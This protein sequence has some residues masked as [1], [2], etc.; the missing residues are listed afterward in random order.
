M[1]KCI[2]QFARVV[3]SLFVVDLTSYNEGL[4]EESSHNGVNESLGLFDFVSNISYF[5]ETTII[6]LFSKVDAFLAKLNSRPLQHPSY[7]PADGDDL[8]QAIDHLR[9]Q[10]A[11]RGRSSDLLRSHIIGG[12]SGS[13]ILGTYRFIPDRVRDVVLERQ[14]TNVLRMAT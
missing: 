9:A 2:H 10:F 14:V 1:K 11:Q 5:R 6:I 12:R 7:D 4:P 13:N 3:T 8:D